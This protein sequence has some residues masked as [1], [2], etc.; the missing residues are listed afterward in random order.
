MTWVISNMDIILSY[1][2][3]HLAQTL[4]PVLLTLVMAVPIAAVANRHRRLRS[5]I[6]S[7][8]GLLY[9]IPSLPLFIVLPVLIG[10]SIRDPLNI[11]I[12]LT[13]YG[14]ALL[15]PVAA[16]AFAT[17]SEDIQVAATALG[18]S[19][20]Q[21]FL[22]VSLPLA[23]PSLTAGLRVVAVS[24]V[25]LVTVGAVLGIDSLG[26]L[27]TDGFQRNILAEVLTG[28]IGTATLAVLFDQLI[29]RLGKILTPWAQSRKHVTPSA[30]C[31]EVEEP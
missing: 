9:A 22:L 12:A 27:F 10:T 5:V 30:T 20:W 4:A 6:L 11:I 3:A 7:G 26:L 15:V 14:L 31:A 21:K 18:Y 8:S 24:T 2:I 1:L 28:I 17:I 16:D 19:P 25:S 23:I 13:L 29:H